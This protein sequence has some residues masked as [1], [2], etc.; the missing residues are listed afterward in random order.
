MAKDFKTVWDNCLET[1]KKSISPQSF[2]TWFEPIVPI[3]LDASS[4]TIQV[5]NKFFYEWLEEHYVAVLRMSIKK[6]LGMAAKLQYQFPSSQMKSVAYKEEIK[7][8][9]KKQENVPFKAGGG[10]N[11]SEIKNPF[12]IPGLKRI[13][14]ES[15]VHP[16]YTFQNFIEGDCNRL[17]RSAGLA[18]SK[19]PG[20]TAF[21]P[22]V[23]YGGVGLGK[24]HLCHAIGN[25]TLHAFPEKN[26]L[27]VSCENFTSQMITAIL[28][29]TVNDFVNFYQMIDVLILDDIQFLAK[30][31]KTQEIF[32][33]IFNQLH[34]NGKQLVLSS[35]RAPKDLEGI[36]D[37][38]ISRFKWGLTADLSAPDFETKMAIIASKASKSGIEIPLSVQEQIAFSIDT[39]IRDLEGLIISMAGVSKLTGRKIDQAL[40]QELIARSINAGVKVLDIDYIA[41]TVC[42]VMQIDLDL[43]K[44][45]SRKREVVLSRQA[46]MYL[47]KELTEMSLKEIGQYFG[48]KDHSTV[49]YSINTLKDLMDVDTAVKIKIE[50]ISKKVKATAV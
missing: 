22:L 6:E 27:Y 39:N 10:T 49:I 36:E 5:P 21:N 17:A 24:T 8:T 32:F 50:E 45:K 37:R 34:Q 41:E 30:K 4:L 38:L 40:A 43:L 14:V 2:K 19:N 28:N 26:V 13:K 9:Q 23:V 42:E 12:V 33:H 25:E 29:G 46:C 1:I 18:V 44:S 31:T 47:S 35:D 48:G 3:K 20:G 15:Q 7:T 11:I 16:N